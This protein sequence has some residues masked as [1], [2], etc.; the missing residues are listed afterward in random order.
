MPEFERYGEASRPADLS[1]RCDGKVTR[2]VIRLQK[3]A[4]IVGLKFLVEDERP[5]KGAAVALAAKGDVSVAL[6]RI[7]RAIED[8]QKAVASVI[9]A[10]RKSYQGPE[11]FEEVIPA[12]KIEVGPSF[13]ELKGKYGSDNVVEALKLKLR[14]P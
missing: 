7:E 1:T 3:N 6:L 14:S 4:G 8:C 5:G 2:A 12:E 9:Y 11:R 10:D 13:D